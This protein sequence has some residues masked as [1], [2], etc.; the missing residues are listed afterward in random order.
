MV[1]SGKTREF[2]DDVCLIGMEIQNLDSFKRF[3]HE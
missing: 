2:E 1:Q 3:L